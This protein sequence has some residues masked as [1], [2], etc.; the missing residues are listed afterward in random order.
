MLL[1]GCF[2]PNFGEGGFPCNP[3]EGDQAC[4]PGLAC[5]DTGEGP[6]CLTGEPGPPPDGGP[7]QDMVPPGPHCEPIRMVKEGA[8]D[9][10][11]VVS[12]ANTPFVVFKDGEG[13]LHASWLDGDK[14][15]P[16]ALNIPRKAEKLAAAMDGNDTLHVVFEDPNHEIYHCFRQGANATKCNQVIPANFPD[17]TK[18]LSFDVAAFGESVVLAGSGFNATGKPA[19]LWL[20]VIPDPP[21]PDKYVYETGCSLSSGDGTSLEL[22]RI[23]VSDKLVVTSFLSHDPGPGLSEWR[24]SSFPLDPQNISCTQKDATLERAP[25]ALTPM[26]VAT[27]GNQLLATFAKPTSDKNPEFRLHHLQ[28]T[29]GTAPKPFLNAP[30]VYSATPVGAGGLAMSLFDELPMVSFTDFGLDGQRQVRL[31]FS[32]PETTSWEPLP[33]PD[34]L[35]MN[36]GYHTR[37]QAVGPHDTVH[38]IF[39]G[40]TEPPQTRPA[41][42]YFAC[43][44]LKPQP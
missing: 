27:V 7:S 2:N 18:V 34:A 11:L 22:A 40:E 4:P 38:V 13:T 28:W 43:H 19:A 9:A 33:T 14:W 35:P 16:Q 1:C 32:P 44:G 20:R 15:Q 42:F 17:L 8:L 12:K 26:P 24:V 39:A 10:E 6:Q 25:E 21:N 3:D 31:L 30:A 37:V 23:S 36:P 41:V 5:K 29:H